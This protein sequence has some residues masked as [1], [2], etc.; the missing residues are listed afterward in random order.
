MV[1]GTARDSTRNKNA[2]ENVEV[3]PDALTIAS[4]VENPRKRAR[5]ENLLPTCTC[6]G[7]MGCQVLDAAGNSSTLPSG[8]APKYCANMP[9]KYTNK[10]RKGKIQ[11]GY[12]K[13]CKPC[14]R[15]VERARNERTAGAPPTTTTNKVKKKKATGPTT[16]DIRARRERIVLFGD[17]L[18]ERAFED[19]GFGSKV[20]DTFRRFADVHCRG[21]SGYNTNHAVCMLNE[22]FPKDDRHPPVLVTVLF[23]SNDACDLRS[24]AGKVQHV[25]VA[26]YENN[27][28]QIVEH[29]RSLTPSPNILFITPP[30]VHDANWSDD[31]KKRAANDPEL[32]KLL[33]DSA[34]NRTNAGVMKYVKAMQNVAKQHDVACVDLH[35][36]LAPS[37]FVDET[38]LIDG[39]HLS[40]AGQ[41]QSA[42]LI[43]E[44][45][46][47]HF[48]DFYR[49]A[50]SVSKADFPDWK[51]LNAD[52]FETQIINHARA[53][54]S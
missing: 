13:L 35:P 32:R 34:P 47:K 23:G 11:E 21:Y 48:P 53:K 25:D 9:Q 37:G 1:R 36:Y 39:L 38:Q 33:S 42:S 31:C 52:T 16:T 6:T 54:P 45:I 49:E 41:R 7:C 12:R 50:T 15:R 14:L 2:N 51:T 8:S 44:A 17:S 18:T 40:E 10:G 5:G 19:G 24:H 28:Q 22:V 30:P 26:R 4:P 46:A 27:L 43:I 29:L 20:Q 3:A